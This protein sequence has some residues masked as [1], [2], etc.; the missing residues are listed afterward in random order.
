[1]EYVF[2]LALVISV[3]IYLTD[4]K[5]WNAT[6]KRISTI[7]RAHIESS[8]PIKTLD[9]V[10]DKDDWE[11][12]FKEIENPSSAKPIEKPKKHAIVK[13]RYYNAGSQGAWP[14][15]VCKCGQTGHTPTGIW[16]E[17]E[18]LER[19]RKQGQNHVRS[20]NEADEKLSNS[21]GNFA[22]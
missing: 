7:A 2:L 8:K 14:E 19:T 17:R 16:N 3:C 12:K 21:N 13:H 5:G 15:W 1:L 4:R 20:M 11:Q 22:W 18:T 6:A 10:K 9:P